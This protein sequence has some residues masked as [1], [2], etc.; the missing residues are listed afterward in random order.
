M[1]GIQAA[2]LCGSPI[3]SV[4]RKER[5]SAT[6]TQTSGEFL[7]AKPIKCIKVIEKIKRGMNVTDS[8]AAECPVSVETSMVGMA[9]LKGEGFVVVGVC[10]STRWHGPV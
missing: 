8:W 4:V 6:H 2:K 10:G 7:G 5:N 3:I 9:L 1:K